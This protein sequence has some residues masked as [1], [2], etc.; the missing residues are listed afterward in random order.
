MPTQHRSQHRGQTMTELDLV[1]LRHPRIHDALARP[2]RP[3][4]EERIN[5]IIADL[6]MIADETVDLGTADD[7]RAVIVLV[8]NFADALPKPIPDATVMKRWLVAWGSAGG[9]FRR[10][11]ATLLINA[12]GLRHE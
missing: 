12:L 11:C 4:P 1:D 5:G 9:W 10:W 8:E 3:T 2:R 7:L 6:N